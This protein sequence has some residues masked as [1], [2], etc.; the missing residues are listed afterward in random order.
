MKRSLRV[1]LGIIGIIFIILFLI[2]SFLF[3]PLNNT[4]LP[5]ENI[6]PTENLTPITSLNPRDTGSQSGNF[7]N[8]N[9]VSENSSD[10][11]LNLTVDDAPIPASVADLY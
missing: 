9:D 11:E 1:S 6:I 2:I 10:N 8:T 7:K 4:N 3:S 5:D